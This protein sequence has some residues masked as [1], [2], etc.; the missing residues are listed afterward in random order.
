[1]KAHGADLMETL[2]IAGLEILLI[3][4]MMAAVFGAGGLAHGDVVE[5]TVSQGEPVNAGAGGDVELP[6]DG[7]G[8]ENFGETSQ[9]DEEDLPDVDLPENARKEAHEAIQNALKTA[10][11]N[12]N[13]GEET[14]NQNRVENQVG[15]PELPEDAAEDARQ[16][17]R[18]QIQDREHGAEDEAAQDV[19]DEEVPE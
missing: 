9:V 15:L 12:V 7:A 16:Q 3:T 17:L 1:M 6:E 10:L 8:P 5:E 13:Q 14:E 11:Q 4:G 18:D 19:V 2:L